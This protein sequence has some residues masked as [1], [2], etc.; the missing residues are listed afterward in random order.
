MVIDMRKL[1]Q[2][3]TK[4]YVVLA[5]L[6]VF[7]AGICIYRVATDTDADRYEDGQSQIAERADAPLS[8]EKK[9]T[10]SGRQETGD[11]AVPASY[12]QDSTREEVDAG[13]TI[14]Q[15]SDQTTYTLAVA[16]GCLQVYILET[17]KLYMETTIAYDLLPEDVREQIDAGKHF[18]TEET[19]L[20]FLES[21]SS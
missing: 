11:V 4:L 1:E 15:E 20:E 14:R 6:I 8:A 12:G 2:I 16:D 21:Y 13:Y 9:R 7:G 3:K 5:V 17:G 18:H 10:Q 19:L